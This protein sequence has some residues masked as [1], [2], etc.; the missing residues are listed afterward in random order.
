MAIDKITDEE[1]ALIQNK[2]TNMPRKLLG[3]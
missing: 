3:I 2:L 1:I